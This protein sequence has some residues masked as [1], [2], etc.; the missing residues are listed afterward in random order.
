[1]DKSVDNNLDE[2]P[3]EQ[4]AEQTAEQTDK[5]QDNNLN[6]LSDKAIWFWIS[7]VFIG[8]MAILISIYNHEKL[9]PKSPQHMV[10]TAF[11]QMF[12]AKEWKPGMGQKP[13]LYHPAALKLYSAKEWKPGMG[14]KPLIYHPAAARGLVWKKLPPRR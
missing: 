6:K 5:N 9:K 1:V 10:A 4:T 13:L 11:N 7:I 8:V 2:S 3:T 12:T 14:Q